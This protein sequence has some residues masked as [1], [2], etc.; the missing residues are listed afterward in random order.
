MSCNSFANQHL[1][2][3]YVIVDGWILKKSDLIDFSG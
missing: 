3:D 1:R 2:N